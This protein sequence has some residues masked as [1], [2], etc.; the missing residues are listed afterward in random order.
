MSPAI[1]VPAGCVGWLAVTAPGDTTS[2]VDGH[3]HVVVL[4]TAD[5]PVGAS[6][7]EPF[8]AVSG[9]GPGN[10]KRGP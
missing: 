5:D 8:A 2:F 4:R 7:A 6:A 1:P 3:G 9:L 10:Q